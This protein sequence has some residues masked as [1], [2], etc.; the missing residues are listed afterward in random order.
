MMYTLRKAVR[1]N[2]KKIEEQQLEIKTLIVKHF[3]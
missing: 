1:Q 3:I 2:E